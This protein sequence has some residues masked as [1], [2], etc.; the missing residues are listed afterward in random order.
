[1]LYQIL[2]DSVVVVHAL[3]VAFVVLG[4]WLTLRWPW[5]G[6]LQIPALTWGALV[7][8]F[9][10]SCPLTPL[11]N[12]LRARAGEAGYA[13]GFI[14]HYLWHALYPPGLTR[15]AQLVLG[16]LVILVNVAAYAVAFVGRRAGRQP[17]SVR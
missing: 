4:G 17:Q 11:E 14:D 5:V 10:W 1:M 13:G 16:S 15:N 8:F 7:E 9:A 12:L 3:F 2:A 6:W